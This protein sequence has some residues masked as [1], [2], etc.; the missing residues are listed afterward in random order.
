MDKIAEQEK[1][2]VSEAELSAWLM[3]QAP[4]YGMTPQEFADAL[5]QSGG[6]QMALADVRRVKALEV[7]LQSANVVDS[8]GANVDLSELDAL[9]TQ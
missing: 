8:N 4:R 3:Q 1:L 6:V 9:M 5:V 2:S 7:V